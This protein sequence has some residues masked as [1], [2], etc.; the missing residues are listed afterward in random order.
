MLRDGLILAAR[1]CEGGE[2]GGRWEFP[3][4]KTEPGESD[5]A[6]IAREFMEEFGVRVR[7]HRFLGETLF[8][9]RG[10]SRVLAAYL[11]ELLP[12]EELELREHSEARWLEPRGLL[13]L[14]LADSDRKLLPFIDDLAIGH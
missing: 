12:G 11:T 7:A 9:H 10:K 3:G 14:D 2:L 6:A 4:G 8:E 13:D 1:R 5:G